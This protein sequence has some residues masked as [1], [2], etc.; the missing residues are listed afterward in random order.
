MSGYLDAPELN[1]AAFKEGWFRTG[2]IGSL[3]EDGFLSLH[4]RL[5]ELINRGGEK[6]APAEIESALLRH[7]AIAEAAAFAIPIRALERTSQPP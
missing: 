6:I 1:R 2:D 5:S 3:D 7:P 4:G